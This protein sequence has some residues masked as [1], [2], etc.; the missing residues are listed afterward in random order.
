MN[1]IPNLYELYDR[2]KNGLC[3]GYLVGRELAFGTVSIS[4]AIDLAFDVDES[5]AYYSSLSAA[6]TVGAATIV[7]GVAGAVGMDPDRADRAALL[8][9]AAALYFSSGPRANSTTA[10]TLAAVGERINE[11]VLNGLYIELGVLGWSVL[12]MGGRGA[13]ALW[14]GVRR[15]V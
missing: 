10:Q 2:T 14:R 5:D 11:M 3:R 7:G 6:S 1:R 4:H 9:G 12:Q 13:G 15:F 8:A